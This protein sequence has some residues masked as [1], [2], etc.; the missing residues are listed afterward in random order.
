MPP[1]KKTKKD[2]DATETVSLTDDE[3]ELLLGVVRSYS[4]QK[5]Y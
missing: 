2:S 4:S 3:K 5:D 1:Q